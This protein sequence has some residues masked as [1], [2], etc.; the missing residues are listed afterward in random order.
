MPAGVKATIAT[1]IL[2]GKDAYDEDGAKS[3]H[4]YFRGIDK[5]IEE[6]DSGTVILVG[7]S[8]GCVISSAYCLYGGNR[9]SLA[10]QVLL[11]PLVIRQVESFAHPLHTGIRHPGAFFQAAYFVL[12]AGAPFPSAI[13]RKVLS[14][15]WLRAALFWPIDRE[16]SRIT[17]ELAIQITAAEGRSTVKTQ[18]VNA[19]DYAAEQWIPRPVIP[20]L[21]LEG[22]RDRLGSM[23][24]RTRLE[25]LPKSAFEIVPDA[26]HWLHIERPTDVWQKISSFVSD[27]AP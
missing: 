24:D 20:T 13:K 14:T 25:G 5:A 10:G 7:H 2:D 22:D 8:L 26:S 1:K 19:D 27:L 21:Y 17:P 3:L 6:S 23:R 4:Q 18:A 16:P 11:S 15:D 9:K 12:V